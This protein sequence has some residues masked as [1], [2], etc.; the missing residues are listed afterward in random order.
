M[1][2]LLKTI[3]MKK[4]QTNRIARKGNE[5]GRKEEKYRRERV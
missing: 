5:N 3:I 2:S 4:K 1:N